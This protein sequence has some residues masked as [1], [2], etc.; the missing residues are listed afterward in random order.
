MP[1]VGVERDLLFKALKQE[2]TEEALDNLCF[3]F[4]I[5]LDDIETNEEG[6][7][8]YKFD[9]GANRY[10]L[11]CIQGLTLALNTFRGISSYPVYS[12]LPAKKNTKIIV[13][14]ATNQIRPFVVGAILRNITFDADNMQNFIDLQDK[15][16]QNICRHRKYASIGTHDLDTIQGPFV[17]DAIVPKDF[18]FVALKQTEKMT[19]DKLINEVYEHDMFFKQYI[20]LIKDSPVYP[21]IKDAN[22]VV[23]SLPPIVNGEHS[24][25]T[26]NTK[27]V[28]I[29]VT[30]LDLTKSRIVL[31]TVCSLFSIYCENQN[32]VESV[33][34]VYEANP[35]R[36]ATYPDLEY[37]KMTVSSDYIN[38]RVGVVQE[39]AAIAESLSKMGLRGSVDPNDAEKIIVEI[40][41]TRS[42]VLQAC[43]VMEDA[44]V[45]YGYSNIPYTMPKTLTVGKQFQLNKLTDLL[46]GEMAQA[47]Y[48]EALTFSLCSR[49]DISK[50]IRKDLAKDVVHIGNPKTLEFQVC[51]TTLLPG[52]LKTIS[53]NK[54]LPL[55]LK[56]FE[57]QDVVKKVDNEVGAKNRRKLAAA[58]Y[59]KSSG[60]ENI[61]GL[62]DRVMQILEV[63]NYQ[64]KPV[65]TNMFFPG[66]SFQIVADGSIVGEGGVVHPECIQNFELDRPCSL[67]EIDLEHFE[68]IFVKYD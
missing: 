58:F 29:E 14:P 22:G 30:G 7:V 50:K 56:I 62:V 31:D 40:P 64:I 13:K 9:I 10:D 60:F 12:K 39:P 51:R 59:S 38:K 11:L 33:E 45:A 47:G 55:P 48:T 53:A 6:K 3:E 2:Y 68:D 66:R 23:C 18:E 25:I 17:Y 5:E 41:P 67:V 20:G 52:L 36:N 44:A 63:K 65:D 16:H 57:I 15:L 24:K 8:I 26:Q 35:E 54:S 32:S 28:F 19:A 61:V 43:D 37:R 21:V 46:R 27:N 34:V 49:D 1:T 42:D 4:G